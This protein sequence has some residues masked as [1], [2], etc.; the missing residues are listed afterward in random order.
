[1]SP[2]AKGLLI[3]TLGVLSISPDTLLIRLADLDYGP[4]LF[5]RSLFTSMGLILLVVCTKRRGTLKAV[6]DLGRPGLLVTALFSVSN[7][8]FLLAVH[9]TTVANTL[10]IIS[11]APVFA[12]LMGRVF[13]GEAIGKRTWTATLIIIAAIFYIFS[14]DIQGPTSWGNLG[15]LTSAIALSATFIVTRHQKSMDMTPAMA[16][17]SLLSLIVAI[18]L[19]GT[20][21]ISWEGLALFVLLG[22]LLTAAFTLLLIAPRHISATEVSLLMPLETIL[23]TFLVW[24][25]VGEQPSE[26]ALIGGLIIIC[27]LTVN[28][29][30]GI[31]QNK[32][33]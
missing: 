13:L 5:W 23:G 19:V 2:H 11:T 10:V 22:G 25:I 29:L 30:V 17:S 18:P 33:S 31:R 27:V 8:A 14:K 32:Q 1:M 9:L 12:A 28:S 20:F 7:L 4:T 24:L 3:A 15:A 21:V 26:R 6:K 16:G